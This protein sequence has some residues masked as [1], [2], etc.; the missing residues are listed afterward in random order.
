MSQFTLRYLP[1]QLVPHFSV[2][3]GKC[4]VRS[5]ATI[6]SVPT[7]GTFAKTKT[8]AAEGLRACGWAQWRAYGWVCPT[9]DGSGIVEKVMAE[10]MPPTRPPCQ[11]DRLNEDGICRRCGADRRG[12]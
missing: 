10:P 11:H 1:G 5:V 2:T 6:A 7:D 8:D 9:C 3:C 12:F 4:K